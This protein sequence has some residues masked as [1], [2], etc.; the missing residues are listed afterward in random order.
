M[1]SENTFIK[2]IGNKL[3]LALFFVSALMTLLIAALVSHQ[4]N[5][6][7][8]MVVEMTRNHLISAVQT[9]A[10]LLSIEELEL[11]QN[12]E[13]ANRPEYQ[14]IKEKLIKFG[15]DYNVLFAYYWQDIGN[16]SFRYIIDNDLD[17]R[18]QIKPGDIDEIA[19][20]AELQALKGHVGVT[21]LGSYSPSWEG[22]LSAFAPVFDNYGNVYCVAGVDIDDN[23]IFIQRTD[24][25][26]LSILLFIT[27]PISVIFGFLN[28]FLYSRKAKQIEEAHIKLQYFNNNLRRAFSTYLSEDVVEEIVNDPTRLKLGGVNRHMTAMFTDVRDF[29]HIVEVLKPEQLV[30]LLNYYL[31]TMSDIILDQKGTIDK[32]QGEAIIS[33]FGAPLELSDHAIRSCTAAILM[34]RLEAKANKY[35]L[36]NNLS[37]SPLFTRIGINSGEM[38]FGNMGT[39]KKMNYTIVSN[40]VNL[41]SKIE[42]INKLY[43]TWILAP[44]NTIKETQGKLLTRRLDRIKA[45]GINEP[46]RIY[47]ILELK[48]EAS[49]ILQE[50][51]DSF[52]KAFELFELKKWKEAENAFE[53]IL[54]IFPDDGPSRLYL[55][56]CR[57]FQENAPAADWNGIFDLS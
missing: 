40:A 17:P 35:I 42:K 33:F 5:N 51:V 23:F 45:V 34:K 41:A 25:R 43:G 4:K 26:N 31:S 13:D 24:S 47:E 55:E 29:S 57:Q 9:L 14:V 10:N 54:K 39:Q 38:I 27:I 46:V 52:N 8:T 53:L 50:L 3:F 28:M 12:A 36:E 56:R 15:N 30:D 22:L 21:D 11:F 32:Y 2:S 48:S 44:E 37:S 6:Y 7:E 18:T 1:N 19:D 49:H 20:E 16:G